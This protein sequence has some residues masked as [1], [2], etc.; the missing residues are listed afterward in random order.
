MDMVIPFRG[1]VGSDVPRQDAY[2]K[3]RGVSRYAADRLPEGV[4]HAALATHDGLPGRISSLDV[5]AAEAIE[6]V[7]LILT[8]QNMDKLA[9]VGFLMAGGNAVQSWQ[10]LQSDEVK[11]F[12]QAVAL[13]VS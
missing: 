9:E 2:L 7:R 1:T 11:Y 10:P 5:S 8:Y 12:G 6:G 4:L 13:V 3:V